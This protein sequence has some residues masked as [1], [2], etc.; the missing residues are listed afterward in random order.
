MA[1]IGSGAPNFA[2]GFQERMSVPELRIY[3]DEKLASYAA[4]GMDRS[5]AALLNPMALIKGIRNN[6]KYPQKKVM[7]D[8]RQMGG[9]VIVNP[10]GTIAWKYVS[11][12]AGDHPP[13]ATIV[14]EALKAAH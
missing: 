8:A 1:V 5:I 6:K 9:V 3:S 11:R 2:R 14:A 13:N 10:D 12:Y 7:G 4:A